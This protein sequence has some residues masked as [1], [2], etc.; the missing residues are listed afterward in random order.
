MRDEA[1]ALDKQQ[2]TD[3]SSSALS[4]LRVALAAQRAFRGMSDNSGGMDAFLANSDNDDSSV[5]QER[6]GEAPRRAN[7]TGRS[8]R[9]ITG[10]AGGNRVPQIINAPDAAGPALRRQEDLVLPVLLNLETSSRAES[11]FAAHRADRSEFNLDRMER[12]SIASYSNVGGAAT[13]RETRVQLRTALSR[14][15]NSDLTSHLRTTNPDSVPFTIDYS[16]ASPEDALHSPVAVS[17]DERQPTPSMISGGSAAGE[18]ATEVKG[19]GVDKVR[20][21]RVGSPGLFLDPPSSAPPSAITLPAEAAGAS[22]ESS[23]DDRPAGNLSGG[24]IRPKPREPLGPGE[25]EVH[26]LPA[27]DVEAIDFASEDVEVPLGVLH[28]QLEYSESE[29]D[30]ES[31]VG[32]IA[33][34]IVDDGNGEEAVD[35]EFDAASVSSGTLDT[36]SDDERHDAITTSES[37]YMDSDVD[38]DLDVA[39]ARRTHPQRHRVPSLKFWLC[40]RIEYAIEGKLDLPT[41]RDVRY[42]DMPEKRY[43]PRRR[44]TRRRNPLLPPLDAE[45]EEVQRTQHKAVN[46]PVYDPERQAWDD[47]TVARS[48][49]MFDFKPVKDDAGIEVPQVSRHVMFGNERSSPVR[50]Y[51]LKIEPGGHLTY[52]AE[53]HKACALLVWFGECQVLMNRHE[54]EL[55][56]GM[57]CLVPRGNDLVIDNVCGSDESAGNDAILFVYEV[58]ANKNP[59]LADALVND[60][61]SVMSG[62]TSVRPLGPI[63]DE[64]AELDDFPEPAPPS[65]GRVPAVQS[66]MR[67]PARSPGAVVLQNGEFGADS[68]MR[69]VQQS[70]APH[71]SEF[72]FNQAP[73]DDTMEMASISTFTHGFARALE[74]TE[75]SSGSARVSKRATEEPFPR[76]K[77]P[78]L[79]STNVNN[80]RSDLLNRYVQH[81]PRDAHGGDVDIAHAA[82][83]EVPARPITGVPPR[84]QEVETATE[85]PHRFSDAERSA[86][87]SDFDEYL[88]RDEH[89]TRPPTVSVAT[90][91]SAL[92]LRYQ[93]LKRGQ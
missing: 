54:F 18:D 84:P 29:S 51:L 20:D 42:V 64:Y 35:A 19:A 38:V 31:D 63:V 13:R 87:V 41:A 68:D 70:S 57:T 45:E 50:I 49:S 28:Q 43:R 83:Q 23:D 11:E 74:D 46:V 80:A 76:P 37:E 66:P 8:K 69:N 21:T 59:S 75:S 44:Y 7:A 62:A 47:K 6:A 39:T 14:P 65:P 27:S 86:S 5:W 93:K 40:E 61:R 67:S 90:D 60:T 22:Y 73:E 9:A 16:R 71:A 81:L 85:R 26:E 82:R 33:E 92:R 2:P 32:S 52:E 4:A 36:S 77:I 34:M 17:H 72:E 58:D 24:F 25:P 3:A 53:E 12:S 15:N 48:I 78:A 79:G 55:L 89:V 91:L 30:D 10:A 88:A 1:L 56:R